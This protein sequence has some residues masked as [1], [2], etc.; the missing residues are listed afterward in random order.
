MN[1]IL[2][3]CIITP[4]MPPESDGDK[5]T[6]GCALSK[7]IIHE[8]H[9][10]KIK[11]AVLSTHKATLLASELLNLHIRRCLEEDP[12]SDL[13][14][15]FTRNWILNAY[16]EVTSGRKKVRLIPELHETR[17][18]YMPP[19]I[20]P[21]RLGIQQCLLYDAENMATVASNN[22][23]MHFGKRILSHVKQTFY[24]NE[25]EYKTYSKDKKR[26]LKLEMLQVSADLCSMP[27]ELLKSNSKYHSWIQMERERLKL[28]NGLGSSNG[29]SFLYYLK[30]NPS[31]FLYAMYIMTKEREQAGRGAFA[32]FPLRRS[33]VPKHIRFDNKA[34]RDLLGLG[35]SDYLKD[36]NKKRLRGEEQPKERRTKEEMVDEN[37]D[38]FSMVLNLRAAGVSRRKLFDYAF[39]TDG[40][41]ARVQ[42]NVVSKQSVSAPSVPRRGIWAIDTLKHLKQDEFHVIGIDPGKREL[43]VGVDMDD[44]HSKKI[45]YTQQQRQHDIQ[46]KRYDHQM[47]KR[48]TEEIQ[49]MENE[50]TGYNSRS[51]SLS[52]FS[53]YCSKRHENLD[54]LLSHYSNLLYR[55]HRWKRGIKTQQS[56]E[57]LYKTISRRKTKD[58]KRPI[59]LAYGSWG[60]VAGRPGMACNKGNP[61]CIGVGLMRKLSKRF[62]VAITPE[63]GT[64]KTCSRCLGSCEAWKEV[65]EKEKR[66]IRGLRRCTQRDCMLPLNRD[67]NAAINIGYNFNR[68]MNDENPIRRMTD[69]EVLFHQATLCTQ[70]D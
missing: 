13:S 61:P 67:R 17:E 3:Q 68:L 20:P 14:H 4:I 63:H 8:H 43:V 11:E 25:S 19:F 21:S 50:L 5:R 22:I 52:S 37:N 60:A 23:W 41:C 29:K 69:E 1:Q 27:S 15:V 2:L 32:L 49:N 40:V 24:E 57:R 44:I 10:I 35:I 18:H 16:N 51:A 12:T 55:K 47:K 6:V 58:D 30:K 46:S 62:V 34:I 26:K 7:L 64:S 53:E 56:E 33:L 59:L 54:L 65:E 39:T 42:M 31:K 28:T 36:R 38:L 9:L 45:S 66:K 48:K 70:C